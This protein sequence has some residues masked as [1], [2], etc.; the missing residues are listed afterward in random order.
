[1]PN[2]VA[3]IPARGGSRGIPGK[4]LIDFCGRPLLAWTV[5]QALAAKT[6]EEV[7]VSSDSDD[8][9]EVAREAGATPLR[10]PDQLATGSSSSEQA[11]AHALD[12]IEEQAGSV[13]G[14]VVFLQATSPLRRPGDIDAA[15]ERF[16]ST[17][18]DSLFS[19]SVLD[20][21]TVWRMEDGR[22]KGFTF[23]PWRRGMRQDRAPMYLENGSIY[24]FKSSVLR[25]YGNR[26]GRRLEMYEMEPW[27]SHEI[28][29]PDDAEL[30]AYYFKN[31]L[32]RA[33]EDVL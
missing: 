13:P 4:N 22:L 5:V 33:W 1:M 30:C 29:G 10:R 16:E 28:D 7:Y 9:L 32:E 8:I 27:Q 15:V 31:R 21:F 24:I 2:R 12:V 6:V 11:L 25:H 18:A 23:D 3:I 20:D 14:T 26:I 19:M 17:G